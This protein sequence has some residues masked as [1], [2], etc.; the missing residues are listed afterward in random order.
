MSEQIGMA[1]GTFLRVGGV[2]LLWSSIALAG[3]TEEEAAQEVQQL[4]VALGERMLIGALSPEAERMFQRQ[5]KMSSSLDV[6]VVRIPT[7]GNLEREL[8][9]ALKRSGLRCGLQL[10]ADGDG[11]ALEP[12]GDC[13]PPSPEQTQPPEALPASTQPTVVVITDAPVADTLITYER[14]ALTLKTDRSGDWSVVDGARG[15]LSVPAFAALVQDAPTAQ[16]LALEKQRAA[17]TMKAF[18]IGGAAVVATGL[19]PFINMPSVST[20][21]GEDRIWTALFLGST[22][23]MAMVIAPRAIE[24]IAAAQSELDGYYTPEQARVHIEA[25]NQ[26]LKVE[27]GLDTPAPAEDDAA[28]AE[29]LVEPEVLIEPEDLKQSLPPEETPPSENAAPSDAAEGAE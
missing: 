23:L 21:A 19:L 12:F 2:L 11:W 27:L 14:K 4:Q 18:R 7:A 22:G 8:G 9:A 15:G 6:D 1:S 25:Y 28:A 5:V 13:T 20:P 17:T 10:S 3:V 16:T 24:G 29:Q 26:A